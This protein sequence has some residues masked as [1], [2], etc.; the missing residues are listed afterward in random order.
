MKQNH[1]TEQCGTPIQMAP[2][3]IDGKYNE[4]CD[5]WSLGVMLFKMITGNIPFNGNNIKE[6]Y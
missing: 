4:K 1:A 5:V 6:L 2:E 3:V